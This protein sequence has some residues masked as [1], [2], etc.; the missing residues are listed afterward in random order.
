CRRNRQKTIRS[1]NPRHVGHR[2]LILARLRVSCDSGL[3]RAASLAGSPTLLTTNHHSVNCAAIELLRCHVCGEMHCKRPARH[4]L[5][6]S[7]RARLKL[8][9]TTANTIATASTASMIAASIEPSTTATMRRA[10][11]T[12]A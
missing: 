6:L 11:A 4:G 3:W 1:Q 5:L 10:T 7:W 12:T 2:V 9:L 8:T